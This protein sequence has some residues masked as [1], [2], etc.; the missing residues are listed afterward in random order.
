MKRLISV[1]PLT[2][3]ETWHHYD[4]LT[5]ETTIHEVQDVQSYLDQAKW[6]RDDDSYKK[7]GIKNSW[8]HVARVPNGVILKWRQEEG[9]DFYN[10]EHWP[11]VKAKLNSPEYAYLRTGTGRI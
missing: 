4:S 10:D 3:T 8:W 2:R 7:Q 1:D 6:L 5:D 11:R 9:I